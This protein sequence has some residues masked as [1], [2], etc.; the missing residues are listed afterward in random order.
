MFPVIRDPPVLTSKGTFCQRFKHS[1]DLQ[2]LL[3]PQLAP[4]LP[5]RVAQARSGIPTSAPGEKRPTLPSGG[6]ASYVTM[7]RDVPARPCESSGCEASHRAIVTVRA[8]W[9]G[10]GSLLKPQSASCH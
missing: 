8:P 9:G 5:R 4:C 2:P 10:L 7:S 3:E 6:Q 1:G